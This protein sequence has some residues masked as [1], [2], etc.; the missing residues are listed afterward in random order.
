MKDGFRR[1]SV[2]ARLANLVA[3]ERLNRLHLKSISNK[4]VVNGSV[5]GPSSPSP[6]PT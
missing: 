3:P 2:P 4:N 1:G 6:R 5:P